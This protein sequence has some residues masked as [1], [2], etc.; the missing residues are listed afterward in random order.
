M[1]HRGTENT[2]NKIIARFCRAIIV[3]LNDLINGFINIM[4]IDSEVFSVISVPL[5]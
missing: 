4:I 3:N 5:W 2:E 1:H